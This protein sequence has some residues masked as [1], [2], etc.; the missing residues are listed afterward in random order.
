MIT[1]ILQACSLMYE[2]FLSVVVCSLILV[3]KWLEVSPICRDLHHA[4][5]NSCTTIYLIESGSLN[6]KKYLILSDVNIICTEA[7]HN[8]RKS[9]LCVSCVMYDV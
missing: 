2:R 5:L 4:Q 8:V 7:L 1:I 3:D 6:E 9:T